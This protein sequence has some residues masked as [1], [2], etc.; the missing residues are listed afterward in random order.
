MQ[1]ES[2]DDLLDRAMSDCGAMLA[3]LRRIE[4]TAVLNV[5]KWGLQAE[6]VRLEQIIETLK[7][8][9]TS[10]EQGP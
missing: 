1:A 8:F 9:I 2:L 10:R 6:E 3:N 7:E 5:V 4:R